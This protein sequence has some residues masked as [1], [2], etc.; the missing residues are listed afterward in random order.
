MKKIF[1]WLLLLLLLAGV[2]LLF[3]QIRLAFQQV[4]RRVETLSQPM[5]AMSTQ[6]ARIL[7][8]TPTVL[9]DPVT[10]IHKV[11]SLAR[12][13]T[14]QYTVEKV[15]TA[16]TNQGTLGFLFGDRLL[17]VAHGVVIA[18]VDLTKMQSED[19]Q[20]RDGVLYVHLP[21]AEVFIATL[22][23]EKSYVYDRDTGLL[24]KGQVHLETEARREAERLIRQAALE[25]RILDTAQRNAEAYLDRLFRS[26]GFPEVVFL[27][28]TP[29]ATPTP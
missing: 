22:D 25:D 3:V 24:T 27:P 2:V 9:P 26:L 12:L 8:P 11:R 4:D 5:Q 14:V 19:L 1:G 21:Q 28:P 13:E 6:I 29:E 7:H 15:V 17:F 20:L 10:I 16:E 18:G 23:N